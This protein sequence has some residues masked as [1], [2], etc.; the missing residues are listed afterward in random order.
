MPGSAICVVQNEPRPCNSNPP[1]RNG[2]LPNLSDSAPATGDTRIATAVFGSSASPA[3]NGVIPRPV[4][5][6]CAHRNKLP[7]NDENMKKLTSTPVEN[8]L[9]RNKDSRSS[10]V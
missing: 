6:N 9:L 8:P 4:T 7:N 5:K 3:S 2:R 1:A 10:G